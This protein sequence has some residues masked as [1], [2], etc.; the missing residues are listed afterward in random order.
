MVPRILDKVP[1]NQEVPRVLHLL[2]NPDLERQPRLIL[3]Q[4]R[5]QRPA[6]VQNPNR[7]LQPLLEPFTAHIF[8]VAVDRMARR[9]RKLRKRI[10][11]CMQLQVAPLRNLHRPLHHRRRILEQHAH[12]VRALHKKLVAVKT[13]PLLVVHLRS[14]LHAQHHVMRVAV[15]PAQIMRVVRRHQRN[16]QLPLQPEQRLVDLLFVLQPLVLNLQKEIPIAE[17]VLILLRH[18]FGLFIPPRH[19]L[20]A[21]FSAQAT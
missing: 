21:Q 8:K 3:M 17:D 5:A 1:H 16:L 2:D 12:L 4:R 10:V 19:Q 14:R 9:H 15:L 20:L 11:H 18:R 13:E 7:R 6:R